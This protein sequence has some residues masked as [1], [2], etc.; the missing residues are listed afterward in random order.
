MTCR[1]AARQR[2]LPRPA[3]LRAGATPRSRT[4]GVSLAAVTLL[5]AVLG[6]AC[7][8]EEEGSAVDHARTLPAVD[9]PRSPAWSPQPTDDDPTVATVNGV[10]IVRSQVQRA[11]EDEGADATPRSVLER[12]IDLEVL[13]QEA[14]AAG[15]YR[16]DVVQEVFESALARELLAE[17]FTRRPPESFFTTEM[18]RHIYYDPRVRLEFDHVDAFKV[19]DAQ[20]VCCPRRFDECDPVQFEECL[21]EEDPHV[22]EVFA[23]L[24]SLDAPDVRTIS[25]RI[26]QWETQYRRLSLKN[27]SFFYNVNL[28]HEE[29]SGYDIINQNVARAAMSV[30]VGGIAAPV[31]SRNGWHI[32][33]VARHDPEEHRTPDDPEVRSEIIAG[34]LPK[35]QEAEYAAWLKAL[36]EM[37][38][39]TVHPETLQIFFQGMTAAGVE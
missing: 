1:P 29:Q 24:Q 31:R 17:R 10:P 34:A 3:P 4:L 14:L 9:G 26:G 13:A 28:P 27:Y 5:V 25:E 23:D 33:Y 6:A 8:A 18:I 12:L 37:H 38:R 2:G 21:Q 15:F 30:E 16:P 7:D 35:R 19:A 36:R 11:L 32:I 20:F 39:V 22:R